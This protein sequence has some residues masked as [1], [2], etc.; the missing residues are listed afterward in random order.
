MF[1]KID[2]D[3]NKFEKFYKGSASSTIKLYYG[4]SGNVMTLAKIN[5]EKEVK[6]KWKSIDK[7]IEPYRR[8]LLR[9]RNV[10]AANAVFT[11]Y[12]YNVSGQGFLTIFLLKEFTNKHHIRILCDTIEY[13]IRRE[14][15]WEWMEIPE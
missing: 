6:T 2:L 15:S 12:R 9:N 4:A 13:M 11:G 7:L 14:D 8:V 3:V 5:E 10:Y 1:N